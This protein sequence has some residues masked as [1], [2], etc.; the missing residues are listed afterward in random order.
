MRVSA[1]SA[2]QRRARKRRKPGESARSLSERSM[3][4]HKDLASKLDESHMLKH[5]QNSHG[6]VGKP[7]FRF[8]VVKYCRTA[9]ERQVGEATRIA[10]RGSTLNS[11]A[12]INRS[13]AARLSLRPKEML[14]TRKK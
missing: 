13:G 10:L 4:H 12:G 7:E 3:N 9:L 11:K 1:P 5:W 8:Q 6:G 14:P 2:T